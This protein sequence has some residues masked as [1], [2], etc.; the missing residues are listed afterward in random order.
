MKVLI[1]G[2]TGFI[3]SELAR[4]F[5]DDDSVTEILLLIRPDS[6]ETAKEKFARVLS[7]WQKFFLFS[8]GQLN[9]IKIISYDL[10]SDHYDLNLEG[11]DFAYHCAASTDFSK[12]LSEN[13][14]YNLYVTQKIVSLLRSVSSLKR[15]VHVSTAFVNSTRKGE[16][17]ESH[18]PSSF[19][20][21]YEQ[22]KFE[23][24]IA[25]RASSLPYTIVRPSIVVGNSHNGYVKGFK[26]LYTL[27]RVWLSGR[28]PRAPLDK[29]SKVDMVPVDFVVKAMIAMAGDE[30]CKGG[31]FHL[32]SGLKSKGPLDTF[33]Y[34]IQVFELKRPALAPVWVA[35]LLSSSIIRPW[36]GYSL[37][38]V[39]EL[40]KWH[41]PYLG[42][43]NRVFSMEKT[44]EILRKYNIECP[45]LDF[46]GETMF[47]FCRD[48]SWGKRAL[49]NQ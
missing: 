23:S 27:L 14:E 9:K 18:R 47:K 46:Y 36:L 19:N 12:T 29:K 10:A 11:V 32:C 24:E 37:A 35:K 4:C 34:A 7:Y 33:Q 43:R 25:V 6:R 39:L 31:V 40:M 48:S 49:L 44:D 45:P 3:G 21:S 22:S 42:D 15:L 2:A 17:T 30:R 28:V 41:I 38:Q 16:V 13:R 1:T 5:L 8:K 26:I 20:N